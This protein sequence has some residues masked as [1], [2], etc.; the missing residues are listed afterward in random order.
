VP[1]RYDGVQ[2]LVWK[3]DLSFIE[4]RS[5][6]KQKQTLVAAKEL[7]TDNSRN[8]CSRFFYLNT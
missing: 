5:E 8:E 2:L 3:A 1:P 4:G 6:D 7:L